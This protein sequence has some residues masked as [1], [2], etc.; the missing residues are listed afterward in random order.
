MGWINEHF[1]VIIIALVII[2]L[3]VIMA[4]SSAST[5]SGDGSA[6][7][8]ETMVNGVSS[9]VDGP[10]MAVTNSVSSFFDGLIHFRDY[11]RENEELRA[12]IEELNSQLVAAQL[13]ASDLEELRRL[14]E[15]L[16]YSDYASSFN[17]A[18][19]NVIA[20]DASGIFRIF[21]VNLGTNSGVSENNLVVCAEGLVG[22][23]RSVG[24]D[25]CKVTG[26]IDS[27][28]SV[29][30]FVRRDPSIIGVVTGDGS[31]SLTGYTF[32]EDQTV[33][34]G[35][36]LVTSGLGY[37]PEG[38]V[39]GTVEEVIYDSNAKQKSIKVGT[40]VDFYSIGL[41]TVLTEQKDS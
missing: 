36:V 22:R 8:P 5:S 2:A 1:K 12:E 10:V 20:T 30:F 39:I 32:D 31:G 40:A 14:S 16:N 34:E 6:S 41:V 29:S 11:Q 17:K 35:D 33:S 23:V 38:I 25:W 15:S 13:S 27:N 37:Y 9:T 28:Y 7:L 18:T 4:L 19:G 3:L 21:T 26:I 24:A